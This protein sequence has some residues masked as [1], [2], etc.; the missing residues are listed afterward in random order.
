MLRSRKLVLKPIL[1]QHQTLNFM[2]QSYVNLTSALRTKHWGSSK[3]GLIKVLVAHRD[4][5]FTVFR[6]DVTK[7]SCDTYE[8]LSSTWL[9]PPE[10]I[11]LVVKTDGFDFGR[12]AEPIPPERALRKKDH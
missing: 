9:Q 12:G 1:T 2:A 3:L 7:N 8:S 6:S 4:T 11:S 10:T 5:N